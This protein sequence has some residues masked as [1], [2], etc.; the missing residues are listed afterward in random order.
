MGAIDQIKYNNENN[1]DEDIKDKYIKEDDLKEFDKEIEMLSEEKKAKV[2]KFRDVVKDD[3]R[4]KFGDILQEISEELKLPEGDVDQDEAM[5]AMSATLDQLVSKL[6]GS[7]EKMKEVQKHVSDLK[8]VTEEV[9][10]KSLN[11]KRDG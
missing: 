1:N 7:S 6:A 10:E 5:K 2:S 11:L 4:Q 8:K 9:T 3:V